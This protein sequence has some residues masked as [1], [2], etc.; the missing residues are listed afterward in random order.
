VIDSPSI[1]PDQDHLT[2][3]VALIQTLARAKREG[4]RDALDDAAGLFES[5]PGLREAVH[6]MAVGVSQSEVQG[7]RSRDRKRNYAKRKVA[8]SRA[9]RKCRGDP[10]YSGM[11]DS[12]LKAWCGQRLVRDPTSDKYLKTLERSQAIKAIDEGLVLIATGRFA[13]STE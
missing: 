12:D 1:V 3:A 8:R 11:S 10:T 2:T 6:S 13:P 9:Y 4:D 5:V 7:A